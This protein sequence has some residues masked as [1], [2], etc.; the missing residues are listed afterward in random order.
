MTEIRTAFESEAI[1]SKIY[2]FR[3]KQVMIDRD[4]ADLFGLETRSL[5]QAV[6]RNIKRFPQEFMFR[7]DDV[8]FRNWVSQFVIQ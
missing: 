4:L 1:Q 7:L 8:E 3:D 5:N 6:K 2:T